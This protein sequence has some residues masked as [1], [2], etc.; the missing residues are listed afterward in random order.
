MAYIRAQAPNGYL[1]SHDRFLM[2]K[3][4]KKWGNA[5]AANE[6]KANKALAESKCTR[7]CHAEHKLLSSASKLQPVVAITCRAYGRVGRVN[8]T[9]FSAH[10]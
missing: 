2:E 6:R 9:T 10:R 1:L 3:I 7:I 8:Y 4:R 5:R